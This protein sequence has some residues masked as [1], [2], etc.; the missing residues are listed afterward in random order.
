MISFSGTS[1]KL[2]TTSRIVM[3]PNWSTSAPTTSSAV[4]ISTISSMLVS[5]TFS[6]TAFSGTS[7]NEDTTSSRV[8]SPNL[9]KSSAGISSAVAMSTMS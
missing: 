9:S 2:S 5:S 6:S 7:T 1:T 3:S 8:M 4:A